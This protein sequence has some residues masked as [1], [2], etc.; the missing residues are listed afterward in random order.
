MRNALTAVCLLAINLCGLPAFG[1]VAGGGDRFGADALLAGRGEADGAVRSAADWPRRRDRLLEAMQR[2]MGPLPAPSAAPLDVKVLAEERGRTFVRQTI[3]YTAEVDPRSGRAER[4]PAYL[5]LPIDLKAGEKR[6]AVLALHPTSKLGKAEIAGAGKPNR[7]YGLELAERGYV[8]ICPDY[9]SFGDYAKDFA[10]SPH[11]SGTMQGIV[12]HRRAV[13]LLISLSQVDG[14]RIGAIGHSLGGHNALFIA[15]FDSRIKAA[16]TSCGW[17][18]FPD[19]YK[20]DLTGW[21]SDRYMPRIKSEFGRSPDRMPFDFHEVI[22]TIAPR[23]VLS[24]SPTQDANFAAEGVRKAVP[25]VAAVYALLGAE[26][27][28]EVE[29]PECAHDFPP[30]M[31]DRAYRFLDVALRVQTDGRGR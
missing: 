6:P 28:F 12:N 17:N 16:V 4:V 9:P 13:D 5:Y 23:A 11:A 22:A 8:V 1:Q 31:R 20:G 7:Q 29:Y 15:A 24:I 30:A 18:L 14:E 25:S 10:A 26:R 27:A 2:V 3:E 19:Y 21:S